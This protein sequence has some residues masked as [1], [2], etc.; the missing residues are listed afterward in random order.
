M[1]LLSRV[2]PFLCFSEALPADIYLFKINYENTITMCGICSKL[3]IKKLEWRHWR[4]SY[5]FIVIFEQISHNVMV[6]LLLSLNK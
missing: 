5:V 3:T 6:F 4:C 2:F 1:L